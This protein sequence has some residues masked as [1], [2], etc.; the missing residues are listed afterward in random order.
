MSDTLP[1]YPKAKV[2]KQP[3]WS[4]VWLIP[5]VALLT[6]S[7]L[8]AIHYLEK[9]PT[10]T[11][12]FDSSEGIEEG[13]THIRYKDVDVG[14]VVNIRL[15]E[16]IAFEP[17][18]LSADADN[19]VENVQPQRKTRV[20]VDAQLKPFMSDY[21]SKDTRFWV[22]RPRV[23]ANEISGLSTLFSGF[24]IGMDPGIRDSNTR[25]SPRLSIYEG[26]GSPPKVTTAH[27]G[28]EIILNTSKL[29]SVNIGAPIYHRQLKV[30]EVVG[31]ELSHSHNSVNVNIHIEEKYATK[32][33]SN[34]RFWNVSGFTIE[35]TPSGGL[36][37]HVE[38][39]VSVL[40]GGIAFDTPENETSYPISGEVTFPLFDN[41]EQAWED[42]RTDKLNYV[43]HFEDTLFGLNIDAPVMHQGI[44]VGKVDSIR[45]QV[46]DEAKRARTEVTITIHGQRFTDE[47]RSTAENILQKLVANGLRAQLKT[48]S[49]LTGAKAVS[50]VYDEQS[51]QTQL[52][53]TTS[54]NISEFPSIRA[55]NSLLEFD[56]SALS[57]QISVLVHDIDQLVS[58]KDTKRLLKESANAVANLQTLIKDMEQRGLAKELVTTLQSLND[59][60]IEIKGVAATADQTLSAATSTLTT[61]DRTMQQTLGD[62]GGLQYR[63]EVLIE[64]LGQAADA[65]SILADSIQRKPNSLIFG[66]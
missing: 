22:V 42:S 30:G 27:K 16:Y 24:Y 62:D 64:D 44:E 60:M 38:S 66:N 25:K 17:S 59:T 5:V 49:L 55:A 39:L 12:A 29:G 11:I 48:V 1:H 54:L 26:L 2:Q 21:L 6:G 51:S 20:L 53:K 58:S 4:W 57:K 41:Y 7:W 9:G 32:I 8:V 50:L 43:I 34:T 14:K 46:P 19:S 15:Q 13:R 45:L 18:P 31:Y 23:S 36:L 3:F 56:P 28:V 63:L 47:Q 65:F 40:I 52:A 33:N 10:V 37:A 35:M 61:A